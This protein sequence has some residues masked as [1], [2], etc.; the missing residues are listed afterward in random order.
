MKA[1]P[2]FVYAKAFWNGVSLIVA[3]ALALLVY[4][5]VLPAEYAFP[6]GAIYA[7]LLAVLQFFKIN[8]ELRA[9]GLIK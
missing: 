7:F 6:A 1:L 5:G 9:K 8:P 2:P 3:G 4:F